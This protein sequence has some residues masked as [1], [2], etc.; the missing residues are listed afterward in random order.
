MAMSNCYTDSIISFY[1][2]IIEQWQ[3]IHGRALTGQQ[4]HSESP[5]DFSITIQTSGIPEFNTES[6]RSLTICV[7]NRQNIEHCALS[8][9]GKG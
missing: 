9:G 8:Y 1:S 2:A 6:F 7:L 3:A 4:T 5:D